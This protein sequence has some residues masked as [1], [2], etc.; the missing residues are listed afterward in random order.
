ML[1]ITEA[2]VMIE[3]MDSRKWSEA[4]PLNVRNLYESIKE[5]KI[6]SVECPEKKGGKKAKAEKRQKGRKSYGRNIFKV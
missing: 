4:A 5:F 3:E 6:D 2:E 1:K